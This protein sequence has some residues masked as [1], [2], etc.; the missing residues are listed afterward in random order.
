MNLVNFLKKPEGYVVY[1]LFNIYNIKKTI[2][3]VST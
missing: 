2:E 1:L 3:M